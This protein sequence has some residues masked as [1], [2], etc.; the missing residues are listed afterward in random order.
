[1]ADK[2]KRLTHVKGSGEATMVDVGDK[3]ITRR[4]AVAEGFIS[5]QPETLTLLRENKLKKGDAVQVAR[6]A[7]IMAAKQTSALIPLCHPLMLSQVEVEIT[8]DDEGARICSTVRCEGKT[9][10]EMEALTACSVAALT[11]YDMCKAVDKSMVIHGIRL[12]RKEGGR[13][14]VFEA[15]DR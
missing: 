12:L 13:S 4:K 6:I 5:L 11:L 15:G 8:L 1:M 14:G 3:A 7:G 9:G 10:V 2:K